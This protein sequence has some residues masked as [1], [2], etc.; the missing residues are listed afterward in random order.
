MWRISNVNLKVIIIFIN[1]VK[2]IKIVIFK[3]ILSWMVLKLWVIIVVLVK[4][5]ISV[6]EEEEGIFFYYVNRF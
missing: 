1:G 4:F 5:L 6:C 3:I 2:K